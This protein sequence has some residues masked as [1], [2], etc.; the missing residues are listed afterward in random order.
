MAD[1]TVDLFVA[2]I[3]RMTERVERVGEDQWTAPTP[4]SE[5]DVRALVNHVCGEQLWAPHLVAGETIDQVGDRYD[6]DVLGDDPRATFQQAAARS[7]EAFAGADLDATVHLSF[8]DVPCAVYLEQMLADAEV[9]GWDL[10]KAL[11][12]PAELDPETA[13]HLLP[14][15]QAQEELLRSS[16]LFGPAVD[17]GTDASDAH[18]L[19]A[20]FGRDPARGAAA[21]TS[22][23][24]TSGRPKSALGEQPMSKLTDD[25]RIDPR[26]KATMGADARP[27]D[28]VRRR[29]ARAAAR[30]DEHR[31]GHRPPSAAGRRARRCSTTRTS[32]PSAGLRHRHARVHVPARRQH[33]EDPATSARRPTRRLPCVYYIHGGGMQVDVRASTAC[34]GPGAGSSPPRVS[35]W[36]WSTSATASSRRRRPRSSPS[37]PA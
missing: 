12:E 34:T 2:S 22:G 8:G 27:A 19:L 20:L 5:W 10:A 25:P 35:P 31:R 11:G 29:T 30:R 15:A 36:P 32:P 16:G 33:R 13:S 28:A 1:R 24:L 37:R 9:H 7:T 21:A 18:K 4:C 17:V 26:I 6:G 23:H 14:G 3:G